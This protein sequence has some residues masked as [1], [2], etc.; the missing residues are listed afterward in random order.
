MQ[1]DKE[2]IK[3]QVV[4]YLVAWQQH[5]DAHRMD[6]PNELGQSPLSQAVFAGHLWREY[7]PGIG[8]DIPPGPGGYQYLKDFHRQETQAFEKA[9]AEVFQELERHDV[10]TVAAPYDRAGGTTGYGLS[11]GGTPGH[12]YELSARAAAFATQDVEGLLA[13]VTIPSGYEQLAERVKTFIQKQGPYEKNVFLIMPFGP[14][15]DLAA[16]RT[17]MASLLRAKGFNLFRADDKEYEDGLWENI[18]VYMLGCKYGIAL[19]KNV[20]GVSYNPNVGVEIG[21]MMA[22]RKRVLILKDT[23]LPR[24]PGD[25]IHRLYHEVDFSGVTSVEREVGTWFDGVSG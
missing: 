8:H 7:L 14:D 1:F 20:G 19:F 15:A 10:I 6:S 16:S 11:L 13:V 3:R 12:E 17:A 2:K 5:K 23:S 24:L 4:G 18:C 25:L 22:V 9:I 21:F